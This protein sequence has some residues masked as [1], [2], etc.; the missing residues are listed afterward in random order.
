MS[1]RRAQQAVGKAGLKLRVDLSL[2]QDEGPRL[3]RLFFGRFVSIARFLAR[4]GGLC[5][6][7][8]MKLGYL[9]RCMTVSMMR[10]GY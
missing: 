2:E 4:V 9:P 6:V 3:M 1:S 10:E 5:V 7:G 8:M